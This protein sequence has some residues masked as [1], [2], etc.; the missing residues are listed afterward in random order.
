MGLLMQREKRN[1][2]KIGIKAINYYLPKKTLT[3]EDLSAVFLKMTPQMIFNSV[4]IQKRHIA[5]K[6]ECVSD[7]SI[8]A[9]NK[10]LESCNFS[11]KDIDFILVNTQSPDYFIPSTACLIQE[12]GG[13]SKSVG[14]LDIG[15]ACSGYVYSLAVAKS[16]IFTEIAK[17]V[18]LITA[19]TYSKYINDKDRSSRM[20][21]GDAATA[22]LVCACENDIGAFDFGTDGKGVKNLYVPAGGMRLHKS[23]QTAVEALDK[24][25]SSVRSQD[26]LYMNGREVFNFAIEVVPNSVRRVL[27]RNKTD[28]KD[29]D[30]FIFHQANEY[31]LRHLQKKLEIPD[32][33]FYVYMKDCG[34]TNSSSIPI[35]L[36]N[37]LNEKKIKR[38]SNVLLCGFGA[39]YSWGSVLIKQWGV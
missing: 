38:N 28:V 34:N 16:L 33:K 23:T 26:N 10:L 27:E 31:I 25:G 18:L 29:V 1:K 22:S 4:G 35:A 36:S 24:F 37:A 8:Q 11:K 15:L 2:M 39:G 6:N 14:A 3:N 32:E 20:I 7:M 17:N 19:D 21:F 12:M 30:L 13:F 9:V 5:D